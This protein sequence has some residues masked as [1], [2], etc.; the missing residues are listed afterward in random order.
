VMQQLPEPTHDP[1][2]P[3][4]LTHVGSDCTCG[5]SERIFNAAKAAILSLNLDKGEKK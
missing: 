3:F 1:T 5:E 2:C 4:Q